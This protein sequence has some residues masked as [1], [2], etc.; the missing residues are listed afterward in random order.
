[1][2][3]GY[4]LLYRHSVQSPGCMWQMG[5]ARERGRGEGEKEREREEGQDKCKRSRD[6]SEIMRDANAYLSRCRANS[7]FI[8]F[9]SRV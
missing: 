2:E 8:G 5:R 7:S 1:M 4:S 3:E 9:P 6:V